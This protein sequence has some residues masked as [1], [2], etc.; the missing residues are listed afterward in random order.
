MLTDHLERLIWQGRARFGTFNWGMSQAG[1]IAIPSGTV[2]VI[3]GVTVYP[4]GNKN[5]AAA[6]PKMTL[7]YVSQWLT[8]RYVFTSEKSRYNLTVRDSVTFA[9]P[10]EDG[11]RIK[12]IMF[13]NPVQHQVYWPMFGKWLKIDVREERGLYMDEGGGEINNEI[14]G[15]GF[16]ES[17]SPF[18]Y[19]SEGVAQRI[20][21]NGAEPYL[22]LGMTRTNPGL[23][24]GAALGGATDQ[25]IGGNDRV[26][27]VLQ[28]ESD[29]T[30]R[31]D[32][33]T[34]PLLNVHYVQVNEGDAANIQ[35]SG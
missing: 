20:N 7:E 4:F 27:I 29:T 24:P 11:S 14:M 16:D 30:T 15:Y 8:H 12:N 2:V 3:L 5:E 19:Q 6:L 1:T 35:P 23:L 18:G 26:D 34:W 32:C 9:D 10:V 33:Y 22:P 17:P 31:L 28:D 21:R 13:N 25:L